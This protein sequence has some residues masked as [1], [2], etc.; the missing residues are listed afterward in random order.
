MTSI[1][2]PFD[3]TLWL[4]TP[5]LLQEGPYYLFYIKMCLTFFHF[6]YI[7]FGR[8]SSSPSPIGWLTFIC[9]FQGFFLDIMCPF[10]VFPTKADPVLCGHCPW[11]TP[12]LKG[13]LGSFSR[14]LFRCTL[15]WGI[16]LFIQGDFLSFGNFA[17]FVVLSY[18]F[19]RVLDHGSSMLP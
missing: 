5:L 11:W 7:F 16:F 12:F 8:G 15:F 13:F 1:S 6:C 2:T 3:L 14:N 9:Q 19:T 17:Y 10:Y 18:I 4:L